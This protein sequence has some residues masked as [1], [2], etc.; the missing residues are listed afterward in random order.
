MSFAA[1]RKSAVRAAR[2]YFVRQLD[3]ESLLNL[4]DVAPYVRQ[5]LNRM[6]FT[7]FFASG[8]SAIGSHLSSSI[9]SSWS[10]FGA[11]ICIAL[12]SSTKPWKE[13]TRAFIFILGSFFGG[14]L[15]APW[16]IW[17]VRVNTDFVVTSTLAIGIGFFSF[18]TANNWAYRFECVYFA[19]MTIYVP[20]ALTCLLID[21]AYGGLT[22]I[23]S[24]PIYAVLMWNMVYVMA[25]SQEVKVKVR[26][27]DFDYVRHAV[28]L[29]TDLPPVYITTAM[30]LASG[31][32]NSI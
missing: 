20:L 13:Y 7:L 6:Y 27:G 15:L 28:N 19:A 18:W 29:Y 10:A 14:A 8:S 16:F 4:D 17:L 11:F 9:G 23:W 3:A 30:E 25:Y 32:V 26:K 24:Y 1:I 21:P 5:H 12:F 31:F 22:D 2:N